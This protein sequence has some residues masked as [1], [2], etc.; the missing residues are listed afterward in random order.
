MAPTNY[1]RETEALNR[2]NKANQNAKNTRTEEWITEWEAALTEAKLH[3]L[4]DVEG[5]RPIRKFIQAVE[6]IAPSFSTHWKNQIELIGITQPE[7]LEELIPDWTTDRYDIE[8][9]GTQPYEPERD[10]RLNPS[11]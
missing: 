9:P 4:P 6:S 3:K 7:K 10:I 5:I 2:W 8:E 11:E 1:A